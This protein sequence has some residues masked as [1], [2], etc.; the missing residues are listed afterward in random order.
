MNGLPSNAGPPQKSHGLK[1]EHLTMINGVKQGICN[2]WKSEIPPG[3]AGN[4]LNLTG[5]PGIFN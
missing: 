2:S 3:N 5:L 4:L 1:V